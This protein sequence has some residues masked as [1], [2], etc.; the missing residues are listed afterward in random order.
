MIIEKEEKI[1]KDLIQ[2]TGYESAPPSMV[3]SVIS[4][5]KKEQKESAAIN[6]TLLPRWIWLIMIFVLSFL[7]IF[8]FY[9]NPQAELFYLSDIFEKLGFLSF[10][11]MYLPQI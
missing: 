2:S 11:K 5:L 4:Q 3:N 8:T 6:A 9:N 1:F 10:D 7:F